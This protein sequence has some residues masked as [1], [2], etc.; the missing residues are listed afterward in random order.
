MASSTKDCP[1]IPSYVHANIGET[2]CNLAAGRNF[3]N[4]K[5]AVNQDD[6]STF[7]GYRMDQFPK[8]GVEEREITQAKA[9]F[10]EQIF[11]MVEDNLSHMI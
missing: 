6:Y 4:M 9:E 3:P 5:E 10:R 2:S 11:T 1:V 7:F 8:F